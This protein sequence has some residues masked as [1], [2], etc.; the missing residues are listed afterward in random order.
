MILR[1]YAD[2]TELIANLRWLLGWLEAHPEV[3]MP[4]Y[5]TM[6]A[7]VDDQGGDAANAAYLLRIAGRHG[8]TARTYE[9]GSASAELVVGR[10]PARIRYALTTASRSAIERM[11]ALD[12]Y[13]DNIRPDAVP[14]LDPGSEVT[15]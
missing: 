3:P 15:R 6:S 4:C 9:D 13:R 7:A 2:R 5:A 11:L 1:D 8:M 14:D 10:G 12:T